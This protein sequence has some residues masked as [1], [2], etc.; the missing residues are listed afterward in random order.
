MDTRTLKALKGS[1]RK[2]EQIRDGLIQDEGVRN[3][4]LCKLFHHIDCLGCPVQQRTGHMRCAGSPYED[5]SYDIDDNGFGDPDII[6][7]LAQAELDFLIS[8]LPLDT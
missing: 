8:L 4:P 5:F 7:T 6:K 1:I 3:C 2:W